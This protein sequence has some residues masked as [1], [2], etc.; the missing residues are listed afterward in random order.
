[1]ENDPILPWGT[2]KVEKVIGSFGILTWN[3]YILESW[4]MKSMVLVNTVVIY[5]HD[6]FIFLRGSIHSFS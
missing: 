3:F 6:I 1:M 4:V 5:K 2:R